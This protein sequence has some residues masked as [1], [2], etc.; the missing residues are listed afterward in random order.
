MEILQSSNKIFA[1]T[2]LFFGVYFF[3]QNHVHHVSPFHHSPVL[4][5]KIVSFIHGF[6]VATLSTLYL[7]NMIS[8]MT[9]S[10]IQYLIIGYS[11]YDTILSF[12]NADIYCRMNR[13]MPLHH[14]LLAIFSGT[15][16]TYYPNEVS[17]GYLS[18]WTNP[19]IHT[20][21]YMLHTP[22]KSH[23]FV[24]AIFKFLLVLSFFSLRICNFTYLLWLSLGASYPIFIAILSL[25]LINIYWFI[26]L[27]LTYIKS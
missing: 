11:I 8:L 7:L 25:Q 5:S 20:C 13:L 16:F 18:E 3:V 27:C 9:W 1:S 23:T 14:F 17:I 2:L 21:Y 10:N 15:I 26:R 22:L 12:G 24:L 6:G 4:L 19:L